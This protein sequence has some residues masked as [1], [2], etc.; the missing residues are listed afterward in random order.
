VICGSGTAQQTNALQ[1]DAQVSLTEA[2]RSRSNP[3]VAAGYYLDAA[4]AALRSIDSQPGNGTN[5]SRLIYN[6]SCQELEV[7]LQSNQELWNRTET[8][9]SR[10]HIYRVRFA[11]GSRVAAIWSPDYFDFFRTPDQLHKKIDAT[12]NPDSWGGTLVGVH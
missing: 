8:I 11:G 3:K 10:N 1:A 2:R 9:Q 5:D 7:L 6:H 12:A 4:D